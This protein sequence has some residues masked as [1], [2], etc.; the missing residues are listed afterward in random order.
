MRVPYARFHSAPL[1]PMQAMKNLGADSIHHVTS[2]Y[3]LDA[4]S[5]YTYT[6]NVTFSAALGNVPELTIEPGNADLSSVGADIA[7]ATVQVDFCSM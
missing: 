2:T 3:E 5:T 6:W 1:C 7:I 4:V